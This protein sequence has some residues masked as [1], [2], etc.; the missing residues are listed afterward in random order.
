M[1]LPLLESLFPVYL[2]HTPQHQGLAVS[3]LCPHAQFSEEPEV[4]A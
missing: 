2:S 3:P 4:M 1:R